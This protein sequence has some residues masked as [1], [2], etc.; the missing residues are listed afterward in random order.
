MGRTLQRHTQAMATFSKIINHFY[1]T[2]SGLHISNIWLISRPLFLR[3]QS[4]EKNKFTILF[5]VQE[6]IYNLMHTPNFLL[7]QLQI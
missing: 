6:K 4:R 3:F 7:F 5:I 1:R 2:V